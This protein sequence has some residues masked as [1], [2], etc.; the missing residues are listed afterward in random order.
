M[1]NLLYGL[2]IAS[3]TLRAQSDVLNVTAHNIANANT[4]GYSRQQ[5]GL[6][7]VA[8]LS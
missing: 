7:P 8:D 6:T 2:N 5:V 4:P 1:G 3:N